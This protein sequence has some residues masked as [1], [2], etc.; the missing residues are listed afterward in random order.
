MESSEEA[1]QV[2]F[3]IVDVFETPFLGPEWAA[4]PLYHTADG[5][6]AGFFVD[7]AQTTF[8]QRRFDDPPHLNDPGSDL[9]VSHFKGSSIWLVSH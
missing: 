7:G 3:N 1:A 2:R 4:P 5:F 8:E 9:F 6:V